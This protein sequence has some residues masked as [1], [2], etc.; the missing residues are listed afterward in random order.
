M[1]HHPAA[2]LA[3]EEKPAASAVVSLFLDHM[4]LCAG[5]VSHLNFHGRR[6]KGWTFKYFIFRD[7]GF[8]LHLFSHVWFEAQGCYATAACHTKCSICMCLHTYTFFND[9]LRI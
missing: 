2:R 8:C 4:M 1:R 7:V 3:E 6:V 5:R 9:K